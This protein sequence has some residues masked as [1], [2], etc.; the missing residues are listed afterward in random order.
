MTKFGRRELPAGLNPADFS[1]QGRPAKDQGD[2][3]SD[4]GIADMACVDQFGTTNASKF[5]HGGVLKSKDGRWWMYTEWGRCKPGNSWSGSSFTGNAQ[6]FMFVGC[7]DESEARDEFRKKMNSKNTK[8]LAQKVI[9]GATIWASVPG[10]DGYLV[11]KLATRDKGLPDAYA[12]K[13]STGVTASATKPVVPTASP[14]IASAPLRSFQPQVIELARALVGGVQTYTRAL[15][16]ASGVTPTMDAIL[17]VR[18]R[19]IPAAMERLK[20]VGS[21]VQVQI[22]DEDL[23]DITKM[24]AA[25]VPRPIPRTGISGEDFILNSNNIFVLQQDLDAFESALTNEDFGVQ[26]VGS[27]PSVDPDSMLNAHMTWLDP[28][29]DG[30]A[31]IANLQRMTNNRH[32]YLSGP[33]RV[34]NIWGV[35]RPDRD[36]Q[37]LNNVKRVV[38][39]RRGQFSVKANLQ[40]SV[41]PEL[42]T[43]EA[44]LYR[45]AN[46]IFTQHGTRSVNIAPITQTHFRLPRQLPGAMICGAN[47]GHGIYASTD[48]KKAVGYTSYERSA[49]GNGGGAIQGRGAFMFLL[50]TIMGQTYVAP[51]TGSWS[52]PPNGCD[53]VFGRGGDR[54]HRLENDEHINFDPHYNRIRYLV[55]F[56]F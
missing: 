17:E 39:N 43:D 22:Q 48:L 3:G 40:P 12:I 47:F 2:F 6:D 24:V 19:L 50:D 37:F 16:A 49:W 25:V 46:V 14:K 51:T 33:M 35:E 4:V 36:A 30:A 56:T 38:A 18:N 55:E 41:R 13:D 10:E 26:T 8:R 23:K 1:Y 28:R 5:F 53:S 34:L 32:G 52:Q 7:S 27:Q 31:I 11:Q 9:A 45:E 20:N 44:A 54:G 15:S 29:G 42:T 21:N